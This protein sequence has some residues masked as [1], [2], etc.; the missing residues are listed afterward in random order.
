MLGLFNIIMFGVLIL[1]F[2][3]SFKPRTNID[4]SLQRNLD[5]SADTDFENQNSSDTSH[6]NDSQHCDVSIIDNLQHSHN[7]KLQDV[8]NSENDLRGSDSSAGDF[9]CS[10]IQD[11]RASCISEVERA[12]SEAYMHESRDESPNQSIDLQQIFFAKRRVVDI[13]HYFDALRN[14]YTMH[15]NHGGRRARCTFTDLSMKDPQS[16]GLKTKVKIECSRCKFKTWVSLNDDVA[17]AM[18]VNESVIAGSILSG[19]NF[20]NIQEL[21]G[22][23]DIPFM[24]D[25][26]FHRIREELIPK[27]EWAAQKEM[28]EAAELEEQYAR[29]AGHLINGIP[30]IV[31]IVDGSWMKRSYRS[32]KHDS[33]SGMACIIGQRTGKILYVGVHNKYCSFCSWYEKRDKQPRQHNCCK[34]WGRDESSSSM[35]QHIVVTGFCGSIET[36]KLIYKTLIADGDSSVYQAILDGNPYLNIRVD[37]IECSNHLLRNFCNKIV[38][39]SKT[40]NL[41]LPK[42]A[43]GPFREMINQSAFKFRKLIKK[44]VLKRSG[45]SDLSEEERAKLLQRDIMNLID[46]VYGNHRNCATLDIDCNAANSTKPEKKYVPNLISTGLYSQINR[47]TNN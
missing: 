39:I 2:D 7:N 43:V 21:L 13:E 42:G 20:N 3:F 37:K 6:F 11:S 36:H 45:L 24:C 8:S 47:V 29:E 40:R 30:W 12:M 44:A 15:Q 25:K 31:V 34:T 10:D 26:T 46:H 16:K 38:E 33:L 41:G 23:I 9:E 18:T 1:T 28:E 4:D 32:G 5:S 27:F 22:A 17:D 19:M 14:V 35:E